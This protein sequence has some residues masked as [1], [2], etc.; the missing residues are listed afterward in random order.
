M[1]DLTKFLIKAYLRKGLTILGT[2]LLTHNVLTSGTADSFASTYLDEVLGAVLLASSAIWT[3]AYQWY[4]KRKVTA[5]LSLPQGASPQT[6]ENVL[7]S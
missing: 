3:A 2:Y 4:V 7:K 1:S 5:A 6:L